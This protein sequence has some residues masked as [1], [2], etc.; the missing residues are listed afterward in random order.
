M[1]AFFMN[2]MKLCGKICLITAAT[3]KITMKKTRNLWTK[4]GSKHL[5][6]FVRVRYLVIF[7]SFEVDSLCLQM[8]KNKRQ[9]KIYHK[10]LLFFLSTKINDK[11]G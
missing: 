9:K 11:S 5:Y 4:Y 3:T 2:S 1:L 7:E 10:L 8:K 6:L